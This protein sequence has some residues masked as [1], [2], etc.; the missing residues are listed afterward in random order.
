[1]AKGKTAFDVLN[2]INSYDGCGDFNL[3]QFFI[4]NCNAIMETVKENEKLKITG[5]DLNIVQ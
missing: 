4:K 3:L 2:F 1:M 5:I